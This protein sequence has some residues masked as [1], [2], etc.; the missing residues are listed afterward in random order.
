V[1]KSC[2]WNAAPLALK[3][4]EEGILV[5]GVGDH[6]G[7]E[8]RAQPLGQRRLAQPRGSFDGEMAELHRGRSIRRVTFS[9][10][11]ATILS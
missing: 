5:D 9:L 11:P 10:M 7:V 2:A 1:K 4:V 8:P 6:R 3:V